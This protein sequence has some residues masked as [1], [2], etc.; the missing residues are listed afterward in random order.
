MNIAA[1]GGSRVALR[2]PGMPTEN[3]APTSP[4][5]AVIPERAAIGGT[6]PGPTARL[7]LIP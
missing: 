2:L 5:P 4:L 7:R 1:A 3:M 6:E